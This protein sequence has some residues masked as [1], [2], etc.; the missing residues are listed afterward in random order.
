MLTKTTDSLYVFP[1]HHHKDIRNS[2]NQFLGF[3]EKKKKMGKKKERER[4]RKKM[5]EINQLGFKLTV[6][7]SKFWTSPDHLLELDLSQGNAISQSTMAI[8]APASQQQL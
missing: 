8:L 7:S 4:E 1:Y 5:K 2:A 6:L 3:L